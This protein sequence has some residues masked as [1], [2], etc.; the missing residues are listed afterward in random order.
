MRA[1]GFVAP[2]ATAH[3]AALPKK[4]LRV[5]IPHYYSAPAPIPAPELSKLINSALRNSG[6]C[7][8]SILAVFH[9]PSSDAEFRI[10]ELRFE[11]AQP[12]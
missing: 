8:I 9:V 3:V 6:G 11:F 1:A 7:D 12:D 4:V 10:V 5:T 2:A